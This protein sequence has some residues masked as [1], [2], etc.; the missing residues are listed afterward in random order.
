[1]ISFIVY[2]SLG[3]E[4]LDIMKCVTIRKM[5][6]KHAVR[7]GKLQMCIGAYT[8]PLMVTDLE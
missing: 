1:V 6:L 4:S 5:S 2:D 7:T 8:N 3:Y